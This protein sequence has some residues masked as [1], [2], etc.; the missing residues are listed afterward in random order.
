MLCIKISEYVTYIADVPNMPLGP[1]NRWD[2]Q[3]SKSVFVGTSVIA[4]SYC[5]AVKLVPY[6]FLGQINMENLRV[7][8]YL[9]VPASIAVFFG[10]KLVRVI[11]EKLFFKVVSYALLFIS[12]KLIWDGCYS[13][14]TNC[15][16]IRHARA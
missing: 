4:F 1:T 16:S 8:I 9:I 7:T 10:V 5:N 15:A 12:L 2:P 6:Y 11:P 14:W 3:L 13:G